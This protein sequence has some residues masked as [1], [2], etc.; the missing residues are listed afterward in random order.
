MSRKIA[1]YISSPNV[2]EERRTDI[3][4]AFDTAQDY[5]KVPPNPGYIE[6]V[7]SQEWA[8]DLSPEDILTLCG[9]ISALEP[10]PYA[11]VIQMLF[12]LRKQQ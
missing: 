7:P 8:I 6:P 11:V 2:G 3:Q 12:E 9:L 5:D 10:P 4:R 1:L